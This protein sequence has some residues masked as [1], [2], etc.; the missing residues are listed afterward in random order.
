MP[1]RE[2][3][4]EGGTRNDELKAEQESENRIQKTG[5]GIKRTPDHLP[6]DS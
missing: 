4:D 6:S 5:A 1:Q 2:D 3:N